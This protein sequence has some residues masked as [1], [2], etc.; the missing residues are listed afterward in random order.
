MCDFEEI[1]AVAKKTTE[2]VLQQINEINRSQFENIIAELKKNS[3][4]TETIKELEAVINDAT[5]RNKRLTKFIKGSEKISKIVIGI[6]KL[7]K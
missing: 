1:E 3:I 4:D 2:K 5:E 6:I 7:A